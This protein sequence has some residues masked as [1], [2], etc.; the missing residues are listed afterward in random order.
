MP[1]RERFPPDDPREWLNRARSNLAKAKTRIVDVYWE[2]LC[3]D[4]QQAAEKAIKAVLIHHGVEFPYVHDLNRLLALPRNARFGDP[5]RRS[6][7]C[8]SHPIRHDYALSWSSRAGL[9]GAVPGSR[10]RV[11][12]PWSTGQRSGCS[13]VRRKA[14]S[15]RRRRRYRSASGFG[16]MAFRGPSRGPDGLGD[17]SPTPAP[18]DLPAVAS[19]PEATSC[20][21]EQALTPFIGE[22][23]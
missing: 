11:P 3:F 9:R 14:D 7:S 2:D 15:L 10:P 16:A 6:S 8:A 22:V 5:G 4:A 12:R 18:Q 17:L 1:P 21:N 13:E 23:G 20:L 19:L